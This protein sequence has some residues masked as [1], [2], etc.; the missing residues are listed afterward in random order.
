MLT[1][2]LR[3]LSLLPPSTSVL[4]YTS[5]AETNTQVNFK[6]FQA[7]LQDFEGSNG[8]V[9]LVLLFQISLFFPTATVLTVAVIKGHVTF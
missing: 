7:L 1:T 3:H 8:L 2:D 6:L 5:G 4:Q 9:N